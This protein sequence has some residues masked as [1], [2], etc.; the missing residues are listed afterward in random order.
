LVLRVRRMTLTAGLA[1]FF[2]GDFEIF[3]L[4]CSS[5][6][7]CGVQELRAKMERKERGNHSQFDY[8]RARAQ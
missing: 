6:L 5:T 4:L 3:A 8:G 7:S 1:V 2:E